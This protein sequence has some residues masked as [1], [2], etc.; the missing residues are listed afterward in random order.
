[1]AIDIFG[2]MGS[3]G[4]AYSYQV[5]WLRPPSGAGTKAVELD[6]KLYDITFDVRI[7]DFLHEVDYPCTKTDL[8]EAVRRGNT[9]S[10]IVSAVLRMPDG[11][12]SSEQEAIGRVPRDTLRD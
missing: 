11:S 6:K 4:R 9:P 10:D 12:F 1:M 8:V 7:R 5:R 2:R 3:D